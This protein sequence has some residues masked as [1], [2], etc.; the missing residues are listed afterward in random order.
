MVRDTKPLFQVGDTVRRKPHLVQTMGGFTSH[1]YDSGLEGVI[2]HWKGT[3]LDEVKVRI[4]RPEGA[5]WNMSYKV[6]QI[7]LVAQGPGRFV[8]GETHP[9]AEIEL[10][11]QRYNVLLDRFFKIDQT[12]QGFT[13]AATFLAWLYLSQDSAWH[14]V[15]PRMWRADGTIN[16]DKIKAWFQ[17]QGMKVDD[18]AFEPPLDVPEEFQH[19]SYTHLMRPKVMWNE[20]AAMFKREDRTPG[21][22]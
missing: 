9:Y 13:N 3:W 19:H 11:T 18:W 14:A 6:E 12:H 4:L 15:W 21:I 17:R 20:V 16:S 22:D 8:L 1:G 10:K 7:E 5:V 2:T